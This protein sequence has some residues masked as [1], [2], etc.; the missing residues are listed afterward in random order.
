MTSPEAKPQEGGGGM[1]PALLAGAGIL[2]VAGLLIFGGDDDDAAKRS[3]ADKTKSANSQSKASADGRSGVAAREVDD[4]GAPAESK[5]KLNP[6]I[7][8]SL[9]TGTGMAPAKPAEPTSFASVDDEIIYWEDQ[10]RDANRMLEIRERAVEHVP[11]I[12]EAIRN[13]NDP[14][15]GLKEFEARKK[16]VADNLD[17]AKKRVEEVEGKLT[18]L[19]GE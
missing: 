4:P 3:A 16:V 15:N 9:V 18:K 8:K 5:V 11:Q 13:G 7:A 19:R 1:L 12:E 17:R 2:I 14:V 10:L 6:R